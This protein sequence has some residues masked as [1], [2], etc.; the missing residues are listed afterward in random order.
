MGYRMVARQSVCMCMSV[1][2]VIAVHEDM[3]KQK[4]PMI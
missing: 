4:E 2:N 3:H 1:L